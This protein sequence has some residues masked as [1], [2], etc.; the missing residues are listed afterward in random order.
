MA[1]II[2]DNVVIT[3]SKIGRDADTDQQLV[4]DE[5]KATIEQVVSELVGDGFI[6]EVN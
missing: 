4:S 1:K 6:V 3:V 2:Q 5:I